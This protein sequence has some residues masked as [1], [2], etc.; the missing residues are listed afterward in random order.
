MKP[1]T[2]DAVLKYRKQL[3]DM[4]TQ[5]LHQAI[6]VEARLHEALLQVQKELAELYDSLQTDK[7]R[8]TTVDRLILFNYRID[9][10]NEQA[11]RGQKELEKQQVQVANKRQQLVKASKDRKIMEKLREQQNAAYAKYL[12][13]KETGMLD[14]IA[15]LAHARK[16]G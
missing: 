9:L 7:E 5:R 6:E 11:L 14:E 12:E 8:G 3:E 2:L 1:F 16:Q 10:V 15:V 4:A 13:K